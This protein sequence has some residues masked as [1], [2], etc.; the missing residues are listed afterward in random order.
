M[1]SVGRPCLASYRLWQRAGDR[2]FSLAIRG[3]F[4]HFGDGSVVQRPV[5]LHGE[6][7]ISIGHGVFIGAG[8][9]L[10]TLTIDDGEPRP[11]ITIADGVSMSGSC[12]LSAV[13][14]IRVGAGALFARNVYIADH[15]H[16]FV[17]RSMAIAQQGVDRIAP[18]V[19]GEGCW[20]A[21]NVVVLPGV[22]I[23]RGAVVGANSVVRAD[24]PDRAVA[25]GA[26]ARVIRMLDGD[27]A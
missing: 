16:A 23:G 8:S 22:T 15:S 5:R 9:W 25:V 13:R 1:T 26:P 21:Q 12:V 14:D 11:R 20:L 7:R 3:A 2:L 27:R 6:A 17:D 18:V 24:V 10:Q 4:A 19:I